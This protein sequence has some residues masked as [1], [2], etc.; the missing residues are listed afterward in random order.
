[1][2]PQPR[3]TFGLLQSTTG[4]ARAGGLAD[5]EDGA[6]RGDGEA[7]RLAD[8]VELPGLVGRGESLDLVVGGDGGLAVAAL[9]AG[10]PA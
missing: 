7:V 3:P 4:P 1:M 8:L 6:V 5:V 9:D 2:V 10:G